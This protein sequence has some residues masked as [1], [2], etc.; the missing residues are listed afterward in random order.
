M[1]GILKRKKKPHTFFEE[2]DQ[3]CKTQNYE[4]PEDNIGETLDDFG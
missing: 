1:Q 4:T 2:T 3:T